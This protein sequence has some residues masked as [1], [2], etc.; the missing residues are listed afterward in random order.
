VVEEFARMRVS[1]GL[2]DLLVSKTILVAGAAVNKDVIQILY[3][4]MSSIAAG[5][6]AGGPGYY[7]PLMYIKCDEGY[8]FYFTATVV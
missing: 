6:D 7:D 4:L 2:F 1:A 8:D 5:A 3:E